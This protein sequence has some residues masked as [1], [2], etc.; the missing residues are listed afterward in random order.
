MRKIKV[1]QVYEM[2]V[3]PTMRL[4]DVAHT[5]TVCNKDGDECYLCNVGGEL[6]IRRIIG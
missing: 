6:M 2:A 5:C 1:K 4:G 3:T